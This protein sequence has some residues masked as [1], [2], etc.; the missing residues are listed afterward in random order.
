MKKLPVLLSLS[1]LPLLFTLA[2]APALGADVVPAPGGTPVAAPAPGTWHTSAELGAITTSGNTVGTSVTGKVDAHQEL[3]VWSN[4]YVVSGYFKKDQTTLADGSTQMETSAENFLIS[5]KAAYKLLTDGAKVYVLASHAGDKFG[6]Y[7]KY[8]SISVGHSSEWI[9][10]PDKTLDVEL[11]P[12]Y[13]SGKHPDGSADSGL[14]VRGAA[15]LRWQLSQNATFT[16]TVSVERGTTN[17]HSTA[18]TA[19]S[20]KINDTMQMKAAFAAKSDTNVPDE[21]K[22]TDTQTSLTLVYSF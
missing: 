4:E 14:T 13:F 10:T 7:T 15:A 6:A 3:E 18:E 12:G 19:L 9:K 22:T 11:G 20:T 1:S 21:K 17:T 2:A 8:S 5:A 16:Q